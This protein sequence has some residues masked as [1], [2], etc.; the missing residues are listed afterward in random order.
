MEPT[1][2]PYR[3]NVCMLIF[4]KKGQIFLGERAVHSNSWQLPQGGVEPDLT[5]KENVIKEAEEEL[6]ANASFF[7][8]EA[9]LKHTHCYDFFNIPSYAIGKFRGQEQT[10]WLVKFSG[11]DKD[12]DLKKSDKE[13]QN[14]CWA[15]VAEVRNLAEARRLPGYEGALREFEDFLVRYL[16]ASI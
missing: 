13:F 9:R 4:N 1:T 14:W 6:G 16:T 11:E 8:I 12:I 15:T 5:L 3:N 2:L 7:E 10:F